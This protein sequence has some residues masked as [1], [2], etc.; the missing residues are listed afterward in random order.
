ME[1]QRAPVPTPP[2]LA[3]IALIAMRKARR[4]INPQQQAINVLPGIRFSRVALLSE[5]V[6][7]KACSIFGAKGIAD[8]PNYALATV[9]RGRFLIYQNVPPMQSAVLGL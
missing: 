4:T 3:L 1:G 2:G 5:I 8:H 6:R 7:D 9:L